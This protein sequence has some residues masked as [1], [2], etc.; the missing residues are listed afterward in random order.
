MLQV[1]GFRFC[2]AVE[3]FEHKIRRR[4]FCVFCPIHFSLFLIHDAKIQYFADA[5]TT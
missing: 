5:L 2:V 4:V 1:S 3:H